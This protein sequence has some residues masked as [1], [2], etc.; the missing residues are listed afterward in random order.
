MLEKHNEVFVDEFYVFYSTFDNFLFNLSL[1]LERCQN[2]TWSLIEK[3]HFMVR[4]RI[5]LD[6]KI[7]YEGIEVD[8]EKIEL[9]EKLL[10]PIMKKAL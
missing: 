5:V 1:L 7:S 4:K 3:C 10:T 9:L 6:H 8:Q 2:L